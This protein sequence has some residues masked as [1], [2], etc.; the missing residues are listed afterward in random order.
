MTRGASHREIHQILLIPWQRWSRRSTGRAEPLGE[1]LALADHHHPTAPEIVPRPKSPGGETGVPGV[2]GGRGAILE[3]SLSPAPAL[4]TQPASKTHGK[5]VTL[6]PRAT[7]PRG[8]GKR[9]EAG[10]AQA[11]TRLARDPPVETSLPPAGILASYHLVEIKQGGAGGADA[12]RPGGSLWAPT[13]D[14]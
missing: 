3:S 8:L 1:R 7:L 13:W 4:S 12:E 11:H 10:G 14:G 6:T 2:G 9:W 5:A